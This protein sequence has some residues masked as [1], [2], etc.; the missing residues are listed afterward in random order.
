MDLNWVI[1]KSLNTRLSVIGYW[2]HDSC[3]RAAPGGSMV[4]VQQKL[5]Y[6]SRVNVTVSSVQTFTLRGVSHPVAVPVTS[7][8]WFRQKSVAGITRIDGHSIRPKYHVPC[9]R[10]FWLATHAVVWKEHSNLTAPGTVP[11][12]NTRTV[13]LLRSACTWGV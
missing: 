2:W 8:V 6:L 1:S 3:L 11:C 4:R 10:L 9:Y 5:L 7:S 12:C 13:L